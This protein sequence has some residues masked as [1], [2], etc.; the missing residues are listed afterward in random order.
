MSTDTVPPL[1][2]WQRQKNVREILQVCQKCAEEGD[3]TQS[4]KALQSLHCVLQDLQMN[5][6]KDADTIQTKEKVSSRA[7]SSL[8]DDNMNNQSAPSS[9]STQEDFLYQVA[10]ELICLER[11]IE[12]VDD[13]VECGGDHSLDNLDYKN[14]WYIDIMRSISQVNNRRSEYSAASKSTTNIIINKGKDIMSCDQTER[15]VDRC[16]D[17]CGYAISLEVA[18]ECLRNIVSGSSDWSSTSTMITS[19]SDVQQLNGERK[20]LGVAA[21]IT[22]L[23]TI[24]RRLLLATTS[25][26]SVSFDKSWSIAV[27]ESYR[28]ISLDAGSLNRLFEYLI[29][30]LEY[31][32]NNNPQNTI[33]SESLSSISTSVL[34]TLVSSACHVIKIPLPSWAAPKIS[35]G[36]LFHSAWK[37]VLAGNLLDKANSPTAADT[38]NSSLIM[39]EVELNIFKC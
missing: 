38:N 33:L 16:L 20:T 23:R 36:I 2:G 12:S 26:T 30:P 37:T 27:P 17:S 24:R 10:K 5:R 31:C 19:S 11:V 9:E 15:W 8:N 13:E 6:A 14:R 35:Y 1:P 4:M 32:N 3:V 21:A 22:S 18:V 29:L 7:V 39:T 34:P 25:T 28:G